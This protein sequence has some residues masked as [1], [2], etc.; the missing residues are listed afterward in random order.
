MD[1]LDILVD[2]TRGRFQLLP[3]LHTAFS[4]NKMHRQGTNIWNKFIYIYITLKNLGVVSENRQIVWHIIYRNLNA[5]H[6]YRQLS[7]LNNE[8]L[9]SF[10]CKMFV[11]QYCTGSGQT[12][13]WISDR[14]TYV[15][16]LWSLPPTSRPVPPL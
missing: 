13:T 14:H 1:I 15:P 6:V 8:F 9:K 11:L 3:W 7:K 2:E 16:S 5:Y 10:Y 12:S 4:K